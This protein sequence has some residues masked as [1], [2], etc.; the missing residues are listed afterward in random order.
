MAEAK[1]LTYFVSL[2]KRPE[3]ITAIKHFVKQKTLRTTYQ[4]VFLFSNIPVLCFF[5]GLIEKFIQ[6]IIDFFH[7]FGII[8]KF[9]YPQREWPVQFQ[10]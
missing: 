1:Q 2:Q 9:C 10:I 3:T 6:K 8:L 7:L 4:F 5:L